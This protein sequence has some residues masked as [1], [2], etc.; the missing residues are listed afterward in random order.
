MA[1]ILII[2]DD[3]DIVEAM[4]VVLE[5]KNH[6]VMD[7]KDG[8][9]GLRKVKLDKPDLII[10]DIMMETSDKGFDVARQLK[11]DEKY[12]TIPI[13]MLT[14]IKERT[15]LDFKKE[16][17]DETWLPVDDYVE[18]PLKPEELVSKVESL[19]KSR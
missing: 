12:K 6:R 11:W 10:L 2:D 13:L 18:K 17:G 7:A 19:L 3:P 4:K 9:E 15:G 14:A 16:A 5:S 1:K 8:E